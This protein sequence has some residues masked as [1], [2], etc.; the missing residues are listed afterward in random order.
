MTWENY[1]DSNR[2]FTIILQ[3]NAAL[4]VMDSIGYR[5]I[6]LFRLPPRMTISHSTMNYRKVMTKLND[7][8]NVTFVIQTISSMNYFD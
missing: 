6:W 2:A 8:N 1:F 7:E 5:M 3:I 4:H